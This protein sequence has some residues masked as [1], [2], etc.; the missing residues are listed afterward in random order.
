M[1]K[2]ISVVS[3]STHIH[4]LLNDGT[5]SFSG[6]VQITGT[7]LPEGDATRLLG[8][9]QN[10]WA[11]IFAQQ[12]TVGAV[13]ELGLTTEKLGDYPTGTVVIWE[14]GKCQPCSKLE[15]NRVIGATLN[16]KEQPIILGAE[17]L[18]VTGKVKSGDWIVTSDKN[19]HGCAAKTKT[20][21]GTRRDLFGKVIAQALQDSEGDSN[22]I[23]CF[24]KKM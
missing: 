6:S 23:K 2:G 9:S 18:L 22:L 13:F 17:Y 20:L 16:G 3:G 24:I 10:R 15:D 7:L 11:D 12:T 8:T 1:T 5:V 14:N 19:G 21:F 4:K